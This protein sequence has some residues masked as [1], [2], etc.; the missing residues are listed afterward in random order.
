MT[1]RNGGS[2]PSVILARDFAP[3]AGERGSSI[4]GVALDVA[5]HFGQLDAVGE[6]QEHAE[7]SAPPMTETGSFPGDRQRL[8]DAMRDLDAIGA[9]SRDRG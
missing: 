9:A 1:K 7:T 3:R 2:S 6:G 8:L 4:D 5:Q